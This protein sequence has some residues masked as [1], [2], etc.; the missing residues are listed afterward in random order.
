LTGEGYTGIVE[1]SRGVERKW[2]VIWGELE[3]VEESGCLRRAVS[4]TSLR[5]RAAKMNLN[6]ILIQAVQISPTG[7]S[8]LPHKVG[9]LGGGY[10]R[11]YIGDTSVQRENNSGVGLFG[12]SS[13][14]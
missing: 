6:K 3:V 10:G 9:L 7:L 12:S 4:E 13:I 14:R 11:D 2:G 8:T 5:E 1:F